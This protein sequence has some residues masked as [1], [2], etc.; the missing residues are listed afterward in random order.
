MKRTSNCLG[1]VLNLFYGNFGKN[2]SAFFL[3]TSL[4][5]EKNPPP[6]F[7]VCGRLGFAFNICEALSFVTEKYLAMLS[8]RNKD[9]VVYI[10]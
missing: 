3:F 9:N 5:G 10:N 1:K 6:P 2:I 8:S 7:F 4:L